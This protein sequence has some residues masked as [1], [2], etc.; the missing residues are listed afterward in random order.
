MD[1]IGFVIT[2]LGVAYSLFALYTIFRDDDREEEHCFP[3]P[4]PITSDET[5]PL[6]AVENVEIRQRSNNQSEKD[7][8]EELIQGW[9]MV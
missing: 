8:D 5:T 3:P 2:G 4:S 1:Y 9:D 6:L 7:S